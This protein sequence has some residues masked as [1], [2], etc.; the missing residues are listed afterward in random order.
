VLAYEIH[1][2]GPDAAAGAER[3]RRALQDACGEPVD[4]PQP[5]EGDPAVRAI[6][7]PPGVEWSFDRLRT[8]VGELRAATRVAVSLAGVPEDD[9]E[10]VGMLLRQ[11]KLL[12]SNGHPARAAALRREA[13]RIR[14]GV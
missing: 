14:R 4:P 5:L 13:E 3:V 6:L 1:V 7:L 2:A 9:E 10:L 8:V 12:D 11:A